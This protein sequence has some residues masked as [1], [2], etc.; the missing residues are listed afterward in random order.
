MNAPQSFDLTLERTIRAPR[1]KVFE[2]FTQADMLRRW[3]GPRAFSI[4]A[5]EVDARVGGRYRIAMKARTGETHTVLGE[6][7]VVQPHERLSF[8]WGWE[9]AEMAAMGQ[10]LVTLTFEEREGET[11]LRLRHTGFPAAE[12][13]DQHLGGWG[14]TLNCLL[15]LVDARGSAAT[16]I[17]YGDP[18]STYTR[19]VRMG[20]A[21]KGLAYTLLPESPRGEIIAGLHPFRRIP[22]FRD[23]D[24][25]LFETS[26]ILRY[27]EESFDGPSLLPGNATLRAQMEQWVSAINCYVYPVFVRDYVI[28]YVFPNGADG[29]PERAVI[30]AA[31]PVMAQHLKVLDSAYGARDYLAGTACSLADL[32]LAPIIHYVRAL[33]EGADLMS[34]APNVS[35]AHEVMTARA[36]FKATA[37]N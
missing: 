14:S 12:A 16:L 1:R 24:V 9:A 27:I 18:R 7:K 25:T 33:P 19:S 36:S 5:A 37:L 32:L 22:V 29:K 6:Y 34:K 17:V 20:L 35:R 26:A 31:V 3:F 2:A 13:R 4:T 15:D 10:T 8:T 28:P 11:L 23:G 21:E 30:D